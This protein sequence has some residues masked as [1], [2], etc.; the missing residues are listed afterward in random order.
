MNEILRDLERKRRKWIKVTRE[1]GFREGI[2]DLLAHQYSRKTHFIFELLQN[3][4]DAEATEAHFTLLPDRLLFS[5]NGTRLFSA[6]NIDRIT[7]IGRSDKASDF[8]KIGKHGIG[9]KAV[10]AY[11]HAPRV[12][13]GDKHFEIEDIVVPRFLDTQDI[14]RD[15]APQETLFILPF[16]VETI[17]LERRFRP[18][19]EDARA[20]GEIS[21]ALRTLS[22]RTLLF[23]RNI[24]RLTW[25]LPTGDRRE[26]TRNPSREP[27][28]RTPT[29][30]QSTYRL[31][32][33]KDDVSAEEHWIIFSAPVCVYEKPHEDASRSEP[34][35]A[36][37]S[38]PHQSHIEVGYL[39]RDGTVS[40]AT[41][42][43]LVVYFPTEKKTELG[44]LIQGPFQTTKARDNI[45]QD[46]EANRELLQA[47]AELTAVSLEDLR[48]L[49]MLRLES[50]NAL[51]LEESLFDEEGTRFFRP[52]YD[53]VREALQTKPLLP[54]RNGH[55]VSA[56]KARLAGVARLAEVFSPRQ[57]GSLFDTHPLYWLDTGITKARMQKLHAYLV[58]IGSWLHWTQQP[59]E[60]KIEINPSDIARR[61]TPEFLARQ[62]LRWLLCFYDYISGDSYTYFKSSP[63]L[64]LADGTQ[65]APGSSDN[66]NA[67]LP[68]RAALLNIGQQFPQVHSS[69]TANS[70][71][72]D[73]LREKVRLREPNPVDIVMQCIL[74]KYREDPVRVDPESGEYGTDLEELRKAYENGRASGEDRRRLSDALMDSAIIACQDASGLD[75][76]IY[77]FQP[78]DKHLLLRTEELQAWFAGNTSDRAFF[79][80]EAVER[81]VGNVF[82]KGARGS[83]A[84]LVSQNQERRWSRNQSR[85]GMYVWP[86][87][88]FDPDADLY[89]AAWVTSHPTFETHS[90]CGI[91]CFRPWGSSEVSGLR[92]LTRSSRRIR[93]KLKRDSRQSDM[94]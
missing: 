66:P 64:R 68:S 19:V 27:Q 75:P 34:D 78:N 14:P 39:L 55:F 30:Q 45:A 71:V 79:P 3:A 37:S 26:Y 31:L 61:L 91:R 22:V 67:Y 17:P 57:L 46:S 62:P 32:T 53:A 63:F 43:E 56:K 33:V 85:G 72:V 76:D 18:L 1:N 52:V 21:E 4:E 28:R 2:A 42:T 65:V 36:N 74:P 84:S 59:L 7:S 25:T 15:I 93:P 24:R 73:F 35:E 11:T 49:G 23:L 51:P 90:F 5:H 50:Y 48:D 6:E 20:V 88:G 41:N 89:G 80:L 10:F 87:F 69:L 44:F 86:K 47:A 94:R 9:F 13:S 38:E 12:H 83:V 92:A 40:P 82:L 70:A 81:L 77:F 60:E 58:G 29:E 54:S 8:T 16:D